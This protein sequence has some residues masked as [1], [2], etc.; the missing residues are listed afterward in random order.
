[1]IRR[2]QTTDPNQRKRRAAQHQGQAVGPAGRG[3]GLKVSHFG[4]SSVVQNDEF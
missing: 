4:E 2:H 1:L 3:G